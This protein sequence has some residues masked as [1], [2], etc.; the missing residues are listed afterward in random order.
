M[1]DIEAVARRFFDK[2]VTDR[3]RAIFEGAITLGATYHQFIGTPICRDE[4]I[5]KA[6]EEAISKSMEL[7]PHKEEVKV[8]I[9]L[10]MIKEEKRHPYDYVTLQGRHL[11]IK[12]VSRYGKV[13]AIL[14][15]R[16]VP[17]LDYTLMYYVER[18]EENIC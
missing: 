12:V 1:Y 5:V 11:D 7:Q 2:S 14:R 18:I 15:M 16:Y 4:R 17:E 3:E 8:R 13:K 6:L 9:N 10:D